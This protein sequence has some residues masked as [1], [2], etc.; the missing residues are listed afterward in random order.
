MIKP[1][2]GAVT[3]FSFLAGWNDILGPRIDISSMDKNRVA[4]GLH[5]FKN[6]AGPAVRP[7]WRLMMAG[8]VVAIEPPLLLFFFAQRSYIQGEI[9]SGIRG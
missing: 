1:A 4:I 5:F 9:V 8:S 2:L 6:N 7:L 3:I